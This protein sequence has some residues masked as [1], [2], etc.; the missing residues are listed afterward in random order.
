[1]MML[2]LAV[3]LL[4]PSTVLAEGRTLQP[5]DRNLT[6]VLMTEQARTKGAMC[7]VCTPPPP[8]PAPLASG[9]VG[10]AHRLL[11]RQDGSPGAFYWAPAWDK[12]LAST[13]VLF[14]EGGGWC[15]SETGCVHR[16]N[17]T[18]VGSTRTD[19]PTMSSEAP[20]KL[21][22]FSRDP[23]MS[24]DFAGANH[25]Y[26][27]YCDGNSFAGDRESPVVTASG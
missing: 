25:V 26:M 4:L 13:W 5:W 2:L 21:G 11:L 15:Y 23:A 14:F 22:I 6:H 20:F 27:R 18:N 7:L 1:M 24:P 8:T 10:S 19:K 16:A 9:L 12:K 3:L 17:N